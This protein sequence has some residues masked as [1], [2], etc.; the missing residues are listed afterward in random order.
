ER[1]ELVEDLLGLDGL[2]SAQEVLDYPPIPP[3]EQ[4]RRHLLTEARSQAPAELRDES[5]GHVAQS[6]RLIEDD[7]CRDERSSSLVVEPEKGLIRR[8]AR[9][10]GAGSGD[11]VQCRKGRGNVAPVTAKETG[12]TP[13]RRGRGSQQRERGARQH[14][15][16]A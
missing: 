6:R 1:I 3:F 14:G 2:L 13:V 8:R 10:V 12:G 4:A 15:V 5:R 9:C 16:A 7:D 11:E